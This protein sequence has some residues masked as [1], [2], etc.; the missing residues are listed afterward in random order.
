MGNTS[1]FTDTSINPLM[2]SQDSTA[3]LQAVWAA[4]LPGFPSWVIIAQAR[5][6]IQS[7]ISRLWRF[8]NLAP[9][10]SEKKTWQDVLP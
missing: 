1:P 2:W 10:F 5:S 3:S 9:P 6:L 8:E 4:R 7:K